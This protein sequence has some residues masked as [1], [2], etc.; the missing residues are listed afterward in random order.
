MKKAVYTN[1]MEARDY[2][3][4][5]PEEPPEEYCEECGEEMEWE[6]DNEDELKYNCKY[7]EESE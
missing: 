4:A 2:D 7:C 3:L 1:A 5:Y 6:I